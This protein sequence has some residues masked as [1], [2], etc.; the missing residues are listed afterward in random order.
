MARAIVATEQRAAFEPL[1]DIDPRTGA[2][3]E[4]FYCDGTLA[5]A[6]GGEPGWYWWGC[7][8][9]CLPDSDAVGPFATSYLA[10]MDAIQAQRATSE[11]HPRPFG[12]RLLSRP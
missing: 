8:A 10:L 6:F 3:I 5:R 2:S 9:G 4:V 12:R 1:Y 11:L 7:Y